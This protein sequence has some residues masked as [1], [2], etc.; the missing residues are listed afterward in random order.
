MKPAEG[1]DDLK[2][3]V[4][5]TMRIIWGEHPFCHSE[6]SR[7]ISNC[8]QRSSQRFLDPSGF[9]QGMLSLDM[10]KPRLPRCD[11]DFGLIFYLNCSCVC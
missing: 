11:L 7:G 10:T 1:A 8:K 4:A 5:R 2:Q 6:R 9:A 3:R